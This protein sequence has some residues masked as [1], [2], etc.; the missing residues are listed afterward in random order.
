MQQ[1]IYT[2]SKGDKFLSWHDWALNTLTEK[3]LDVYMNEE[4]TSEKIELYARWVSEEKIATHT[5]MED[6]VE[7]AY[8][9]FLA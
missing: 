6:G 1:H 9:N 8:T 4:E 3:E 2:S 7:V 5:I